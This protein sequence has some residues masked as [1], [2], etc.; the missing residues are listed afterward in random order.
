[1]VIQQNGHCLVKI[2]SILENLNIRNSG[3]DSGSGEESSSSDSDADKNEMAEV[4]IAKGSLISL[5]E[6]SESESEDTTS[7]R[8]LGSSTEQCSTTVLLNNDSDDSDS[9]KQNRK[10][11]KVMPNFKSPQRIDAKLD[12]G[13]LK[14]EVLESDSSDCDDEDEEND[15]IVGEVKLL[16]SSSENAG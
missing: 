11:T 3:M 9:E 4:S 12:L 8:A 1:M 16:A 5:D 6:C 14:L 13:H 15:K 2:N 10:T 7:D